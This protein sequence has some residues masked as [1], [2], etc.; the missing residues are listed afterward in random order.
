MRRAVCIFLLSLL[1]P[2][3]VEAQY[4]N[5]YV[6]AGTVTSQIEGDELKGFKHWGFAGGVGAIFRFDAEGTWALSAEAAYSNRGVYNNMHTF[7]N[8]YNIRLNLRYVDIPLT[9]HFKDPIGGIRF[10]IGP[11][12]S[13]L[14]QQPHDTIA[15]NPDHFMPDTSDLTF[16]RNDLSLAAELRFTVWENLQLSVRYQHSLIPIK[17]G[18]KFTENGNTWENDCYNQSV[19]LRLLWQFGEQ[20]KPSRHKA[21]TRRNS[22]QYQKPKVNV[23]RRR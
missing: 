11:V 16:L 5:T 7:D 23:R 3:A 14:V 17:K 6:A 15:F 8:L 18:W 22:R 9:L 12:Y 10:G 20:D 4:V 1:L 13:R 2:W 21:S 19:T